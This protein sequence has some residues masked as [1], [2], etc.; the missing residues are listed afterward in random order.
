MR[1]P[2]ALLVCGII[3]GIIITDVV[4]DFAD[5]ATFFSYYHRHRVAPFP[6]NAVIPAI[7]VLTFIDMI[8]RSLRGRFT[9]ILSLRTFFF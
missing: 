9:D 8:V 4:F 5:N 1:C 3:L 2:L 7:L 6:F